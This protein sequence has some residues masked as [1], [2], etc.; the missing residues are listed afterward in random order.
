VLLREGLVRLLREVGHEVVAQLPDVRGL[1]A[2]AAECDLVV[3]DVR[4]PPT[5]TNEGIMAAL[6]L[7]AAQPRLPILVLS[8]YVEE[9][10]AT[11]L[12][13]QPGAG[14]GYLL[15][16]RVA[17]LDLFV[18]AIDRVAAGEHVLDPDV[19]E[20]LLARRDHDDRLD[21]LTPRERDVLSLMAQG[22]S[23]AAIAERLFVTPGA[24]EKYISQIFQ[25]LGLATN[26][27]ENRRVQAVLTYLELEE[28]RA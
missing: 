8:Q 16:D 17:D 12:I 9:R 28:G 5:F 3:L 27:S 21:A 2:A 19:I 7:R 6:E 23:N 18:D 26:R 14:L 10:Y 11:E 25:K 24:I 15:K 22:R 4:L 20:Q 13:R 1:A